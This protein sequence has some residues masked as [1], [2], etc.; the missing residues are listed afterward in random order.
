MQQHAKLGLRSLEKSLAHAIMEQK[1]H[2]T[3]S[4]IFLRYFVF[5]LCSRSFWNFT[6]LRH[7][8]R[9]GQFLKLT[10]LVLGEHKGILGWLLGAEKRVQG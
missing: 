1:V 4:M 9:N 5:T 10:N 3:L 8:P 6:D 7:S 2:E